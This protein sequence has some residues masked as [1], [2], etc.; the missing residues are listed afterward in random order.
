[1]KNEAFMEV[2]MK[3]TACWVVTPYT[4]IYKYEHSKEN[5]VITFTYLL[6]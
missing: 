5:A 4:M 6:L 1:M 3:V 2:I